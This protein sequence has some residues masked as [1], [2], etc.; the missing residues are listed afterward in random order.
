MITF[1]IVDVYEENQGFLRFELP[2]KY[3]QERLCIVDQLIA[4]QV[5]WA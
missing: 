1:E 5:G 4:T 2:K 3:S